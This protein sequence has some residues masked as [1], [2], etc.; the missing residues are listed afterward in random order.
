M[1]S[2]ILKLVAF[3][4]FVF[5]LGKNFRC[6]QHSSK[7]IYSGFL[8]WLRVP[9][10][11]AKLPW[12]SSVSNDK[13]KCKSLQYADFYNEYKNVE[14]TPI[15]GIYTMFFSK[16]ALI[17]DPHLIDNV[18]KKFEYFQ[19]REMYK[20]DKDSLTANLGTLKYA[21]WKPL[22]TKLT[23]AFSPLKL[24]CMIPTILHTGN[25]F[26]DVLSENQIEIC[27]IFDRFMIDTIGAVS[28]GLECN[29]LTNPHSELRKMLQKAKKTKLPFPWN[30]ISDS[31]PSIARFFGRTKHD[32]GI[33]EFFVR[34]FRAEIEKRRNDKIARGD[35]LDIL[36]ECKNE[37]GRSENETVALAFDLLSAGSTDASIAL[38]YCVYELSLEENIHIQNKARC[39]I[40]SVLEEYNGLTYE[41]LSKLDYCK[42]ILNGAIQ[43]LRLLHFHCFVLLP[44]KNANK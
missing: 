21:E 13:S 39:E 31:I 22:R 44:A 15:V 32:K 24:K 38:T 16:S 8:F 23:K 26:V 14:N 11:K 4:L 17:L 37:L 43:L 40:R 41:A 1:I 5:V 6:L 35:Y 9:F 19:N 30:F 2:L 27:D 18:F 7:K 34:F 42:M 33:A 12:F 28:F 29:T 10:I 25:R 3:G 36:I 20:N